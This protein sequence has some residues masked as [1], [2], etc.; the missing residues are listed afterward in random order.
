MRDYLEKILEIVE[1]AWDHGC[2]IVEDQED[3]CF[4]QFE[5]NLMEYDNMCFCC[6][7]AHL[8][9]QENLTR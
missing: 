5:K 1:A 4:E 8:G 9:S 6:K 3:S 2:L 7:A